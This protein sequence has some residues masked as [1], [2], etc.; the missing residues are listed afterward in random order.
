MTNYFIIDGNSL[1]H[2]SQNGA[3]LSLG[4]MP[5]QAVYNFLRNMR[6]AM[7][8]HANYQPVVLWDGA[9]WRKMLLADYK[10]NREKKETIAERK[11][12]AA[13]DEYKRQIPLIKKAL[14]LLGI[15]QVFAI[16][17]E[18]DDLGAILADRYSVNGKVVL[19]TGDKDWI[20]LVG[21][22]VVWRDF[23]NK[24]VI[25]HNN[26]EEMTGVKTPVQFVEVKALSGDAGDNIKGVGGL[27][28]KGA[29]D[30]LA[31]FGSFQSFLERVTFDKMDISKRPK[32]IR[33]L[34]ED[35]GKAITFQLNLKLMDLRTTAR[36]APIN[37]TVDKGTPNVDLFRVF[38]DRLLFN[39][40]TQ[41]LDEW[42]RV[43]PAFQQ[44]AVAA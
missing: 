39:S 33:D 6:R 41:E 11:Q 1:G 19:W 40:I 20:Q 32:K 34:V 15:P 2:F 36:P 38:C 16:N 18:A 35:E 9:S 14:Q 10:A 28:E 37:L 29:K 23:A 3:R 13:K 31:E 12:A 7:A 42:I 22:N 27:G 21:P 24:R 44:E 5:V 26:F 17:M 43:F 30:F 25:N 8:L 4:D